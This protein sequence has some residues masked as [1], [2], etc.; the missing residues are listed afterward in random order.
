LGRRRLGGG[1]GLGD[2]ARLVGRL[3]SRS[4]VLRRAG[5]AGRAAPGEERGQRDGERPPH[6]GLR[7]A[8]PRRKTPTIFGT[9]VVTLS[10]SRRLKSEP[11]II[12][13]K[14]SAPACGS[15][16]KKRP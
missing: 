8:M 16:P 3:P 11:R 9:S 2:P 13:M 6:A 15:I 5:G 14:S 10:V 7:R 4:L 12:P 1:L